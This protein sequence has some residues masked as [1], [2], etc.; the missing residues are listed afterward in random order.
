MQNDASDLCRDSTRFIVDRNVAVI[1]VVT[2]FLVWS[3]LF[4]FKPVDR[5]QAY[6]NGNTRVP[7]LVSLPTN[8]I[9]SGHFRGSLC[10]IFVLLLFVEL[11]CRVS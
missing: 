11:L 10:I 3:W 8:H 9:V 6:R 4:I 7:Y 2:K 5:D 1:I